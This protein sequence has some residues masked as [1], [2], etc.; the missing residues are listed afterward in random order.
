MMMER[1]GVPT[2]RRVKVVAVTQSDP[3]F[4]GAFFGSFLE[5]I[6]NHPVQIVEIV[7]LPNF[8]ESKAALVLRLIRLYGIV[9]FIRLVGRYIGAR[10]R[11]RAGAP[12][13]VEAVAASRGIRVRHLS[14]INSV[15][16]LEELTEQHVDVLLSVAAPEIFG[17]EALAA[18]PFVLNVHSGKLPEYR[19]MMPTFWALYNGD[20]QIV[21]TVHEMAEKVDTG[22]VLAEFPLRVEPAE[23]AFELAARA[24]RV[25]G[26]EV[27]RL[28]AR[29]ETGSWP[30][31]RP[32]E[33]GRGTYHG[34]PRR[35]DARRLRSRG[36]RML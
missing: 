33:V 1:H 28:L 16:Y 19:G 35:T 9:D 34:F 21:V 22:A 15:G 18:A 3:F 10:F 31:P 32:L 25:A 12:R 30:E 11:D 8:N 36:R 5:E 14:T 17:K 4:T 23:S 20:E 29:L 26:R 13:T 24:K 27:A 7:L 6:I 2:G